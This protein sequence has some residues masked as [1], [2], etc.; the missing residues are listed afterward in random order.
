MAVVVTRIDSR[1]KVVFVLNETVSSRYESGVQK[2]KIIY[3]YMY[4]YIRMKRELGG[5]TKNNM[6]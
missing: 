3:I 6:L 5:E 1:S 2:Q 4:V